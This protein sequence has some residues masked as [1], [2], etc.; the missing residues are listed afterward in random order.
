MKLI[1]KLYLLIVLYSNPYN[2][3]IHIII[4]T[5]SIIPTLQW[6]NYTAHDSPPVTNADPLLLTSKLL[7][8]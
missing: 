6:I 4:L 2:I 8:Y 5:I 7:R 3:L 1:N